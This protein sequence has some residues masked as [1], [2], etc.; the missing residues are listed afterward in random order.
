MSKMNSFHNPLGQVLNKEYLR[1]LSNYQ[2][3]SFL[4]CDVHDMKVVKLNTT[5]E[6]AIIY[7]VSFKKIKL[8]IIDYITFRNGKISKH[9][10]N[11]NL[12]KTVNI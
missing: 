3:Y 4:T 7:I 12:K 8:W 10:E 11:F 6:S 2:N 9:F 1:F 5:S